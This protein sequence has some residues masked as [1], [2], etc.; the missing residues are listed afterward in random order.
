MIK[1]TH[2]QAKQ[3]CNQVLLKAGYSSAH[4]QAIEDVLMQA[5]MDDCH[6]HGLYRLLNCVMSLQKNKVSAD[7][8]PIMHDIS[9]SVLKVDA[10]NAMAPLAFQ[11]A[12]P[13]L[14]EKTKAQGVALLA[15]NNCVHTTALWYE[16]EQLVN[17]GLVAFVC[18]SNHAWVVPEGG[19]TPLFGTNP[20]AFGWPRA[21][22]ENPFIF[23]FSTTAMARGDIELYRK[24]G[25]QLPDGCGVDAQ[26]QLTNDPAVIL[27]CGA[28]KTFGAHKGSALAAM[29]ELLAGPLIGDVLSIESQKIDAGAGGSPL[30]GEFIL[31][32][33]PERLLGA[34]STQYIQNAEQLFNGYAEQQIRMPSS[35]RY[36]ARR[37]NLA[38]GYIQLNDSVYQDLIEYLNH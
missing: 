8:L 32:L 12:M 21:D 29:I 11:K 2:L 25:Q 30:G 6:S 13:K 22:D 20:M 36:Q 38:S 33:S 35:R 28:M 26:G 24:N 16:V 27:D 15:L 3:L 23:D 31:A 5:Q 4:A 7:S 34:Q 18:T 37:D 17:A 19:R 10:Q 14:V 9:A 1:L